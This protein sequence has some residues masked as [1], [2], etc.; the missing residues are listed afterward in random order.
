MDT[1]ADAG[2][3]DTLPVQGNGPPTGQLARGDAIGRFVI[4]G[5]LGTGGMGFVYSAYDP[6]LDRKIAIKF[7]RSTSSR[8]GGED[9]RMRLLR[10]AQAMARIN[11]ANVIKV[12]DVGTHDD[13]VYVAMEFADAGTLRA[14]LAHEKRALREI[15][16][17]F[18]QAGRGLA[19]AHQAGLIHRDFK[20][21]NVLMSKD[22]RALVTDFGLV[23]LEPTTSS[24][25]PATEPPVMPDG[26]LDSSPLSSDL[27]RTGAVMGTPLYMSPEQ[28]T[29]DVASAA[30]DQFS[31]C[32]TLYEAVFGAHPFGGATYAELALSVSRGELAP[33]ATTRTVP[34]WLRRTVVRGLARDPARRFPSMTALLEALTRGGGVRRSGVAFAGIATLAVAGA[35]LTVTMWP[36]HHVTCAGGDDRIAAL[37]S[38]A[39]R[40]DLE[41]A[42]RASGRPHAAA[43]FAKLG[44][45]V[46]DWGRKW[47]V[48]HRDA[49]EA[50][51][52]RGEQSEHMLDLRMRCLTA[53]LDEVDATLQVMQHDGGDGVDHALDAITR[54]PGIGPCA[55]P[56]ALTS[57]VQPPET[58]I[59]RIRVQAVQSQLDEA[60]AQYRLGLYAASR[61]RA[62]RALVQARATRYRPIIAD[63]LLAFGTAQLQLADRAAIDNLREALH[64]ARATGDATRELDSTGYLVVALTSL[65]GQY[66]TALELS[67]L[68]DATAANTHAHAEQLL[69]LANARGNLDVERGRPADA[70]APLEQAL[71]LGE[72][73]LGPDHPVV[74]S[75]VNQLATVRKSQGAFADARKLYERALAARQRLLGP[76]H[77]DLAIAYNNLGNV[78]RGEGK[79][80]EAKQLY[81]RSLAIRIAA[82]GPDHPE[83]AASYN[84]LGT[85]YLDQGD[86]VAARRYLERSAALFEKTLGPDSTAHGDALLNLG[87]ALVRLGELDAATAALARGRKI[88]ETAIGPGDPHVAG[89]LAELARIDEQ[90]GKLDE[91]LVKM[92]EAEEIA[93]R[94]QGHDHPDVADFLEGEVDILDEQ[95][96]LA[97]A[98][99]VARHAHEVYRAAYGPDH[100]RVAMALASLARLQGKREDYKAALATW[101]QTLPIF[102]ATLGKNHP[103]V[104]FTLGGI[105]DALTE[106]GR[107]QEA[108][109]Y[110][111][112]ALK[113]RIDTH[114]PVQRV[115][116]IHYYLGNALVRSPATRTRAFSE[117]R[118]A[119]ALYTQ[120]E[121]DV[122]VREM[123]LWLAKHR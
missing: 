85:F 103:N 53:R 106:L 2:V 98:E 65:R 10:E 68:A 90:R 20:P 50:T 105:G 28:F 4:L 37:W 72:R 6:Q 31:F 97:D 33:L 76:D 26:A 82:L 1:E 107:P 51:R 15:V 7:L 61:D 113:I 47:A 12:H 39:R 123:K 77:P 52:V 118:T 13:R 116:E 56:G 5:L 66:E 102:E 71:A 70:Q 8:G 120:D 101:Q 48:A 11:H 59:D 81:E 62:S 104:S 27:T 84:N 83:V 95:G 119:L 86:F 121:D 9:A 67:E 63:A 114:M 21:D 89:A 73:E 29:G 18:V 88:Y 69:W 25:R 110:L 87:D 99:A 44:A 122:D 80:D 112:R 34:G 38:P 78:A 55:D 54:I 60:R 17:V 92:R 41:A 14:W 109:P 57:T 36:R 111:E 79:L 100:P 22:G 96:K 49:C 42:F 3:S 46:D 45:L 75:T 93:V 108:I 40:G 74:I 64:L 24:M 32:V 115:A 117:I 30:S 58:A 16:D 91:A 94:A 43:T 35:G 19:A 23:G